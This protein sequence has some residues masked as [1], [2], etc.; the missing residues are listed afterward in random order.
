MKRERRHELHH[1]E[2]LEWINRVMETIG[3]YTNLVLGVLLLAAVTIG[4]WKWWTRSSANEQAAAW[5]QLYGALSSQNPAEVLS[6]AEQRP[7]SDVA[8]WAAVVAGDMYLSQGCDE[9]FRSKA[10]A[11]QELRKAVEEYLTVLKRSSSEMIR[12]RA[13]FGLAR[14]YEALAGTSEG[15]GGLNEAIRYY[16]DVIKSWP[17]GTYTALADQ[18]LKD[19]N[20]QA[21]KVFYDKFAQYDP[22]P[23][24]RGQPGMPGEPPPFDLDGLD[25]QDIPDFS[26]A[27]NLDPDDLEGDDSPAEQDAP[28]AMEAASPEGETPAG[29]GPPPDKDPA[30]Q[31]APTADETAAP[32]SPP[33]DS[34]APPAPVDPADSNRSSDP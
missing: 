21:T 18:R 24:Y 30:K 5:T 1:N 9:L 13:T 28:E 3:P 19:L 20:N 2:L 23:A 16:E 31:G 4:A 34:P 33:D 12:E 11:G 32:N 29:E 15:Q 17:D 27:L 7:G 6:V 26:K 22:Q 25:D 10:T 14:A 8:Y